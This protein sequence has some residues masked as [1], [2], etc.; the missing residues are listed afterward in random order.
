MD[1]VPE[2]N[3]IVLTKI[4][5]CQGPGW[6]KGAVDVGRLM[7]ALAGFLQLVSSLI[8]EAQLDPCGGIVWIECD[9]VLQGLCCLAFICV[10]QISGKMVVVLRLAGRETDR[11]FG[12]DEGM[13]LK[14]NVGQAD[15]QRPDCGEGEPDDGAADAKEFQQVIVQKSGFFKDTH[16]DFARLASMDVDWQRRSRT[17]R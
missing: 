9:G 15:P 12:A 1:P 6:K 17:L 11:F 10:S 13:S 16:A 14:I 7:L 2:L 3:G 8:E 4:E 5:V